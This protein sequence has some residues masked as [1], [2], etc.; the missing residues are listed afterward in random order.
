ME[1]NLKKPLLRPLL[2]KLLQLLSRL[3]PLAA[4]II[5]SI[6]TFMAAELL[7]VLVLV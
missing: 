1:L 5:V 7:R 6:P 4:V 2:K 3:F